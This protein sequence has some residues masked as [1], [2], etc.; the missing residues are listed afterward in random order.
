MCRESVRDEY[1]V[2]VNFWAESD[3]TWVNSWPRHCQF[4]AGLFQFWSR[5]FLFQ[6]DARSPSI[7]LSPLPTPG[8][9]SRTYCSVPSVIQ[10]LTLMRL[11]SPFSECTWFLA[12][13]SYLES[14][15]I[16]A[17]RSFSM[18]SL[19]AECEQPPYPWTRC[20]LIGD[21]WARP[22]AWRLRCATRRLS[23]GSLTWSYLILK[24]RK[25]ELKVLPLPRQWHPPPS[26]AVRLAAFLETAHSSVFPSLRSHWHRRR[27]DG[28]N[29]VRLQVHDHLQAGLQGAALLRE[30]PRLTHPLRSNLY[31]YLWR[32]KN[33]KS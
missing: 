6:S 5:S 16:S 15:S 18:S 25:Y 27:T 12:W 24:I 10:A 3:L 33:P 23:W 32:I 14:S 11:S 2:L 1:C 30:G 19:R 4:E 17:F 22:P 26:L 7:F 8:T 28:G 21:Y 13:S 20:S 31:Y 9:R 29:G